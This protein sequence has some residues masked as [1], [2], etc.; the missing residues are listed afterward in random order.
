VSKFVLGTGPAGSA[1]SAHGDVSEPLDRGMLRMLADVVAQCTEAFE[2]YDYTRALERAEEFFWFFC[3]DYVELVKARGY[4]QHGPQAAGSA[5]AAL[6]HALSVL[7][8]LFAPVLP[9]V[10]EEV[11]SW[12]Q[13]GSVHRAAWPDPA[14]LL[15]EAGPAAGPQTDPLAGP[16][17]DSVTGPVA[18]APDGRL[19]DVASA[20]IAAVR[21][22]KS[23][24]KLSMRANVRQLVVSASPGDLA[25]LTAVLRDVRD[26]GHVEHVELRPSSA[27]DPL[28]EVTL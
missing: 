3:D 5:T 13:E 21:K 16:V 17:T 6:R 4:G 28:Y 26:A 24:A 25:A 19:L 15:A 8:R 12:W 7:L 27:P 2:S 22:A 10:T 23:D 11:W 18:G 20:A 9:F 14:G 1:A